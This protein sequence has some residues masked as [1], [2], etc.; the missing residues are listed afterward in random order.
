MD[1]EKV[2]EKEEIKKLREINSKQLSEIFSLQ[3]KLEE[4]LIKNMNYSKELSDNSIDNSIILE[5]M[6]EYDKDFELERIEKIVNK[7]IKLK[8]S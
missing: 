3:E 8:D 6:D 1:S 4:A 7:Q 5:V 2:K